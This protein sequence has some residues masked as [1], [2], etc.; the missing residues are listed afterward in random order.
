MARTKP[1]RPDSKLLQT[2]VSESVDELLQKRLVRTQVTAA[3]YLR[4]LVLVDLGI[5]RPEDR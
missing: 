1:K 4:R 2:R 3:D 5:I